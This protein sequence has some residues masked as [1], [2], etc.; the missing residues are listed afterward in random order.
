MILPSSLW[1]ANMVTDALSRKAEGMGGLT[2]IP[3]MERPLAMDVKTLANRFMRFDISSPVG[4]FLGL[5]SS[6][7]CW[8]V[9]SL[10]NLIILT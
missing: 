9:S 6:Y 8:S 1:K 10:A 7:L 3:V 2:F 5:W 4:F